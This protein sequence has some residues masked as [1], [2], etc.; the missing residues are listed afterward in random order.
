MSLPRLIIPISQQFSVRYLLRTELLSRISEFA[1]P[2]ALLAWNDESLCSELERI[3]VEVRLLP[4]SEYARDY[5]HIQKQL[6][7]YH[8][9][10]VNS[11]TTAIDARRR[12]IFNPAP[13]R[14]QL[15]DALYRVVLAFPGYTAWM[16]AAQNRRLEHAS[17]LAVFSALLADLR[18]D[19]LFTITP[20]LRSEHLLLRAARDRGLPLATSILSF[21]NLTTRGWIPVTFDLYMV[22][23]AYNQAEVRRVYPQANGCPVEIVGAPQMD[24]YWDP[25]YIWPEV[26]WRATLSLPAERPV[27]LFGGGPTI[28]VQNEPQTLVHLD[29]AIS[30]GRIREKPVILLRPHPHDKLER[31]SAALDRCRH[32]VCDEPWRV[33]GSNP[34]FTNVTRR[35]IEKLAS[36]LKHSM[37]HINTSSTLTIDGAIFDRPQ[38]GPAYDESSPRH[39]Q[40]MGKLYEREHF[41]P[42]VQSGGLS[43]AHSRDELITLV[44]DALENPARLSENRRKMVR[45]IITFDDG[46][47]TH[48]LILALRDFI[49]GES[50]L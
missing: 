36:T 49:G 22:W 4:R 11:S 3:G 30:A 29:E 20:F 13:L 38:I 40:A 14:W 44:N 34:L 9:T 41:L 16:L 46:Q 15:R 25:A 23:N 19:A 21:D 35:D 17:N 2:V 31:W 45:S 39:H 18:A 5:M 24:F 47:S 42:I 32:V 28:I 37:V 12:A 48:R 43:L 6:D 10:Q 27:I 26:E 7:I 33:P 50:L 1:Q 8:I